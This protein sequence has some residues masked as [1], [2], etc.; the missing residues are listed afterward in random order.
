MRTMAGESWKM[1]AWKSMRL[2]VRKSEEPQLH[3]Q[4]RDCALRFKRG[5]VVML[6]IS[7]V[8]N[9]QEARSHIEEAPSNKLAHSGEAGAKGKLDFR[10]PH[11]WPWYAVATD[12][13]Y[14]D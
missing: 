11:H 13:A 1:T 7:G 3:G 12:G 6:H 14:I 4:V 2:W 10:M 8:A 5:E 9:K